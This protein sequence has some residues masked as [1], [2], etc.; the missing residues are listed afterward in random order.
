MALTNP[1]GFARLIDHIADASIAY[2]SAQIEAGAD[3]V[4]IF[5]TWAGVLDEEGVEAHVI[6][7][8]RR[9]VE[10]VRAR[11]PKA[12]IIGF[13][14]GL[15]GRLM[16]YV[17][18]TGVDAVG[19]DWTVSAI[20][21]ASLQTRVAVQ[22]NLDPMR[23]VL[24]GEALDSGVDRVLERLG[25]GRL[26]FNLGHGITPDANPDHLARLVAR[27]RASADPAK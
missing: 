16:R 5:D 7:P 12:R 26:I 24:G 25:H 21:A 20:E 19:L 11:H 27:V 2:L 15:A 8:T 4:Q 17:E 3:A 13:P 22:G 18:G 14:K 10:G 23:V 9:I 1:E 6:G